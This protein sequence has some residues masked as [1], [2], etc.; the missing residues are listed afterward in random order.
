[1]FFL[2]KETRCDVS[3]D[4]LSGVILTAYPSCFVRIKSVRSDKAV[5]RWNDAI[6]P[7]SVRSGNQHFMVTKVDFDHT[8]VDLEFEI[9][10]ISY[11]ILTKYTYNIF[12][13]L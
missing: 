2:S 11:L 6:T 5:D 1:M 8:S 12:E 3:H 10:L 7:Q 4:K 13:L 9:Y